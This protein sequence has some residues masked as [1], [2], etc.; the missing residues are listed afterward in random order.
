MNNRTISKP[1]EIPSN[2]FTI[3]T[4]PGDLKEGLF[5]QVFLHI[6]EILPWLAEN[7]LCPSWQIKSRKYGLPPTYL[8]IPG[9]LEAAHDSHCSE[10]R[11]VALADIRAKHVCNLGGDWHYANHLWNSFFR[12]P[13]RVIDRANTL[14]PLDSALALHY[15]G[16][17]KNLD[18]TQTNSVSQQDFLTLV[19]D[20][21]SSRPEIKALF[22]ATDEDGFTHAAKA[23]YGRTMTIIDTGRA[24]FW[25]NVTGD[26][27]VRKGDH[28]IL[29]CLLLS[30]CRYML[31]CQ[32][33]L[34]GF[35]KILNPEMLSYRVSASKLFSCDVPYFPDAYIERYTSND[36]RCQKILDRLFRGDWRNNAASFER[37]GSSFKHLPRDIPN[38][39]GWQ[40]KLRLNSLLRYL[41]RLR[42]RLAILIQGKA[43]KCSRPK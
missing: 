19:D 14:G 42:L 6:F 24:E 20:F 38:R 26:A 16:T 17:D 23:R 37:F 10:A 40:S 43:A 18:L 4:E 8:I 9:L 11:K 35:A 3:Y 34:S 32:S 41:I 2:A 30:R 27:N 15:R 22:I 36:S 7:N 29:D 25:S 39:N 33:A 12:L 13:Q 1:R 28:A 31:K 21:L 5:G